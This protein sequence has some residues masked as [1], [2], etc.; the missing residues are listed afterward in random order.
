MARA[1]DSRLAGKAVVV[2]PYGAD[3]AV[4]GYLAGWEEAMVVD[5]PDVVARSEETRS[6]VD[7]FARDADVT[8]RNINPG[9]FPRADILWPNQYA[10]DP[11]E[12]RPGPKSAAD[13][14]PVP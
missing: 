8:I 4:R 3:V 6:R 5:Y 9:Y 11:G 14:R 12:F 1:P 7:W 10:L 13:G 2:S